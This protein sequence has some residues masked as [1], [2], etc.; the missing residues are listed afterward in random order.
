[1]QS[2]RDTTTEPVK[3][4]KKSSSFSPRELIMYHMENPDEPITDEDLRNLNL[5]KE[6]VIDFVANEFSRGE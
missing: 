4:T 5:K 6:R 1:M 2:S 3:T